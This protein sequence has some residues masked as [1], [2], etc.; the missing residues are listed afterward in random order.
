MGIEDK[1]IQNWANN[2]QK[3]FGQRFV[4]KFPSQA[5]DDPE[6]KMKQERNVQWLIDTLVPQSGSDVAMTAGSMLAGGPVGRLF[7]KAAKPVLS[8]YYASILGSGKVKISDIEGYIHRILRNP[9]KL[10]ANR[11][12]M[13]EIVESSPSMKK[14]DIEWKS[15]SYST[16]SEY[17]N[18]E[19]V[20]FK[21][22]AIKYGKDFEE[23]SKAFSKA[24]GGLIK[25]AKDA[26]KYYYGK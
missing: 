17:I 16:P 11:K 12:A 7:G 14:L 15:S 21:G 3:T 1:L 26:Y 22:S 25:E 4:E 13:N 24:V 19:D 2:E 10:P 8:K 18:P 9:D 20:S 23:S 5:K 6:L